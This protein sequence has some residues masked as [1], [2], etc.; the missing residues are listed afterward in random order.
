MVE[1]NTGMTFDP[2]IYCN[3][4]KGRSYCQ[5]NYWSVDKINGQ[6]P[7]NMPLAQMKAGL[8]LSDLS[9]IKPWLK[10]D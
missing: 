5:G 7:L 2:Q 3:M 8:E 6:G 1:C 9:S 10:D 4:I